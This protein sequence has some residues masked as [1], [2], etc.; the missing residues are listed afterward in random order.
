[1][2]IQMDTIEPM[3][4]PRQPWHKPE[5]KRLTVSLDTRL[6]AGSGSD[7]GQATAATPPGTTTGGGG[8]Y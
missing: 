1:M 2:D 6:Y 8:Y 7:L 3:V 4:E 5:V